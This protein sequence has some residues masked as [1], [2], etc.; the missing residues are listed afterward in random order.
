[1]TIL[2]ERFQQLEDLKVP[3]KGISAL[4]KMWN[5]ANGV[6]LVCAVDDAYSLRPRLAKKMEAAGLVIISHDKYR[7]PCARFG[8]L[9]S[10]IAL[11]LFGDE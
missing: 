4:R 1:M 7:L 3:A 6:L 8:D 2:A 9:G 10:N 11:D 5:S